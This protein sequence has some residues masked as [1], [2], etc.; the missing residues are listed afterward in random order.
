MLLCTVRLIDRSLC[1]AHQSQLDMIPLMM[2]KDYRA[3]GWLGLILGTRL[4]YSLH[5][6]AI[7]TDVKFQQQVEAIVRGE[8]LDAT[9]VYVSSTLLSVYLALP[10]PRSL[11][12]VRV[13]FASVL[14]FYKLTDSGSL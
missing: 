13:C 3:K 1:S 2:Q 14:L 4:Y 9:G 12:W 8:R 10:S 11:P 5:P 6:E 7:D